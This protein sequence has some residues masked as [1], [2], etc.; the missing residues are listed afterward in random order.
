[1]EGII[2]SQK[3]FRLEGKKILSLFLTVFLCVCLIQ[4]KQVASALTL[5]QKNGQPVTAIGQLVDFVGTCGFSGIGTPPEH[6]QD[7]TDTW[8]VVKINGGQAII[9]KQ[10]PIAVQMYN[11]AGERLAIYANSDI[12]QT[13]SRWWS[14]ACS[15][16]IDGIPAQN[17][18][19]P[20]RLNG[21]NQCNPFRFCIADQRKYET[22]VDSNPQNTTKAFVLS[23]IDA[24]SNPEGSNY[25]VDAGEVA[26]TSFV[27]GFSQSDSQY[28]NI[29]W[30][31]SPLLDSNRAAHIGGGAGDVGGN[32]GSLLNLALRPACWIN[33]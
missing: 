6:Q 11:K 29:T 28:P 26:W 2:M 12:K 5:K 7:Q 21:E 10:N 15:Q 1:M 17:Y 32:D 8:M 24:K 9:I 13:V 23:A 20:V 19:L 3:M 16:R 25:Y 18:A 27:S 31:R 33:I 14:V 22:T 30:L 4:V